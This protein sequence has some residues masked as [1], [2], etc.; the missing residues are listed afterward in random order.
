MK[1]II[2]AILTLF[3]LF[4]FS[5]S[6]IS[7]QERNEIQK[8]VRECLRDYE[9]NIKV[10]INNEDDFYELFT[11]DESLIDDVYPSKTFSKKINSFDWYDILDKCKLYRVNTEVKK[12]ESFNKISIDSGFV[13][14][15]VGKNVRSSWDQFSRKE[16]N[17]VVDEKGKDIVEQVVY[18]SSEDFRFTFHY[19]LSADKDKIKCKIN[20][21]SKIDT[22]IRKNIYVVCYKPAT[23]LARFSKEKLLTEQILNN[24]KTTS[25]KINFIKNGK[26]ISYVLAD[27]NINLDFYKIE[28]L[29]K[30]K[31]ESFQ[32]EDFKNPDN[33]NPILKKIIYNEKI[34]GR[35]SY[36]F[37]VSNT[38]NLFDFG[39]GLIPDN[40]NYNENNNFSVSSDLWKLSENFMLGLTINL[41]NS[42][43]TLNSS[44]IQTITEIPN[45]ITQNQ[46]TYIRKNSVTN[47]S[48]DL[49]FTQSFL[50]P[51]IYYNINENFNIF[52]SL[53]FVSNSTVTSS[54]S[55]EVKYSG[56][57]EDNFNIE[58]SE[59]IDYFINGN[60][61][62][63]DLGTELFNIQENINVQNTISIIDVGLNYSAPFLE[64]NNDT[65]FIIHGLYR[66]NREN[67]FTKT[68]NEI[69]S[70]R[71]EFNSFTEVVDYFI[72]TNKIYLGLTFEIGI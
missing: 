51:T 15:I 10:G 67:L 36:S 41:V 34:P 18:E 16:F 32:I 49:S 1:N 23:L 28:G 19:N 43:T 47:F 72:P 56:I 60:I 52:G 11:E 54:R 55:G 61:N 25:N 13:N 69:S 68:Q 71:N 45:P 8:L 64:I 53:S 27:E 20:S 46:T 70:N 21:I 3:P 9:S 14:V 66:I 35:L 39:A 48:E 63:L 5:Q 37:L 12:W 40:I 6:N 17:I 24:I 2:L 65:K 30:P 26:K 33:Y 22:L 29:K 59:P 4:L 44:L 38:S 62:T 58:I 7:V 31:V 42:N 57:F 50:M